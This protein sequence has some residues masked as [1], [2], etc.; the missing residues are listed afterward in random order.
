MADSFCYENSV[1]HPAPRG[2]EPADGH[3]PVRGRGEAHHGRRGRRPGQAEAEARSRRRRRGLVGRRQVH[4]RGSRVRAV[5]HAAGHA[6]P[7]GRA[8]REKRIPRVPP[9]ERERDQAPGYAEGA[10]VP[11]GVHTVDEGHGDTG[12]RATG[13]RGEDAYL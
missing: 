5:E 12:G 6:I 13:G 1:V 2:A 3:R 7:R 4:L 9:L 11:G 8:G 10:R